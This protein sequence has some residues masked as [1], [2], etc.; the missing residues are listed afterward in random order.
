MYSTL[1]P[2][3]VFGI[4]AT[5][6]FS[7]MPSDAAGPLVAIVTP[8]FICAAATPHSAASAA[9]SSGRRTS[10]Q[11]RAALRAGRD[12]DEAPV[13]CTAGAAAGRSYTN[14]GRATACF[15]RRFTSRQPSSTAMIAA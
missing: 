8:T 1:T 7:G 14:S 2:P 13:G 11:R 9:P 3:I 10:G 15:R 6:F 12:M 5:A 4:S